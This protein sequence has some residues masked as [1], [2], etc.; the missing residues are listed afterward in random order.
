LDL[1]GVKGFKS[2]NM[3]KGLTTAPFGYS[4]D[5]MRESRYLSGLVIVSSTIPKGDER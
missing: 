3:K 1:S 2:D 4:L 5:K